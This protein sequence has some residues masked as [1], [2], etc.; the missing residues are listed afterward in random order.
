MLIRCD[1]SSTEVV[2]G[3]VNYEKNGIVSS[4]YAPS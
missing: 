4:L 3:K 2:G 1:L